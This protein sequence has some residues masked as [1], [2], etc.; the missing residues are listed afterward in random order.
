M[1]A[2]LKDSFRLL[3]ADMFE[4]GIPDLATIEGKMALEPSVS[5]CI[6]TFSGYRK[7]ILSMIISIKK[8]W[9]FT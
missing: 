4:S 2:P 6:F 3:A 1:N 8:Y 7:I 5:P 9:Q